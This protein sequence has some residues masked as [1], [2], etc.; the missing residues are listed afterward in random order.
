MDSLAEDFSRLT[1]LKQKKRNTN[2]FTGPSSSGQRGK[3]PRFCAYYLEPGHGASKCEKNPH[4]DHSYTFAANLSILRLHAALWR[5]TGLR[6]LQKNTIRKNLFKK[7]IKSTSPVKVNRTPIGK[8]KRS[9]KRRRER[10]K[11]NTFRNSIVEKITGESPVSHLLQN[12]QQVQ[13]VPPVPPAEEYR[14]SGQKREQKKKKVE[15]RVQKSFNNTSQSTTFLL[16]ARMPNLSS[17]SV[18]FFGRKLKEVR[19]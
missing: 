14:V 9:S 12:L 16:S 4:H 10:L 1:L 5:D 7:P 15:R 18:S 2:T 11:R 6:L 17:R 3:I 13:I 8:S 19:K